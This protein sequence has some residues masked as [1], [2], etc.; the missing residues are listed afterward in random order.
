MHVSIYLSNMQYDEM[1][2]T[3]ISDPNM[4]V[5]SPKSDEH[6][7]LEMMIILIRGTFCLRLIKSMEN[8][9]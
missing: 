9:M 2:E 7:A 8:Y 1:Y 4:C 6:E 3:G 5:I